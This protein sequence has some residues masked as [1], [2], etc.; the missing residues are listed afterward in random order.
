M[1]LGVNSEFA[2]FETDSKM[3]KQTTVFATEETGGHGE[4]A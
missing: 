1:T 4:K 2:E 3:Y